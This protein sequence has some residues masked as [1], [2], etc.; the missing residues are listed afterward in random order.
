MDTRELGG[1][2]MW[3]LIVVI[4]VAVLILIIVALNSNIQDIGFGL[5][6]NLYYDITYWLY[7]PRIQI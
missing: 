7:G 6:R 4:I 5:A 1:Q 2:G 3:A